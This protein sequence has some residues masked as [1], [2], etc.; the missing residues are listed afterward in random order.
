VELCCCRWLCVHPIFIIPANTYSHLGF[1]VVSISLEAETL[2]A[3]I[4]ALSVCNKST[5]MRITFPCCVLVFLEF[6]LVWNR[7]A[8]VS[9]SETAELFV[10]LGLDGIVHVHIL[11]QYFHGNSE[12]RM[13]E[14]IHRNILDVKCSPSFTYQ[15]QRSIRSIERIAQYRIWY[16]CMQIYFN[17]R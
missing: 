5:G 12:L 1:D 6:R 16:T 3:C 4:L 14:V 9:E 8:I 7:G 11:S 13:E 10:T 15:G 2:H 17:E